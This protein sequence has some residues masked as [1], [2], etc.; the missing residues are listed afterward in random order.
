MQVNSGTYL[1]LTPDTMVLIYL[2]ILIQ[3]VCT[4]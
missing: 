1:L 2:L 4:L 3:A